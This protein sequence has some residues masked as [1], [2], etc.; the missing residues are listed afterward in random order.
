MRPILEQAGP[1]P[2]PDVVQ[3]FGSDGRAKDVRVIID[4]A[5]LAEWLRGQ[6]SE[7]AVEIK[8]SIVKGFEQVTR[9]E[10]PYSS[11]R[12]LL[13]GRGSMNPVLQERLQAVLP[14]GV[15]IHRFREPDDTNLA[16]PTVKLAT[17]LGILTLRYQ[18]MAP[19]A[20][21]DDRATFKYLVGRNKRGKLLTVLDPD[22]G[23]DI[24]REL[25]A[26][27]RPEVT[28]LYSDQTTNPQLPADHSSIRDVV[29]NLGYDAVGYRIY[30]RAVSGSRVEVSV[31]PRGGRPDEDAPSWGIDL[32]SGAAE[33]LS[34]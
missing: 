10:A 31:G 21:S 8:E 5:V 30:L 7:A 4:R 3:L 9:A 16:A 34:S 24:W 22:S 13:G 6:L 15:R 32:I 28:V 20:V 27:N 2:V 25:G 26:C 18:P 19:T 29:C 12:I 33:P 17:A 23:Y 14:Q 11:L 1:S